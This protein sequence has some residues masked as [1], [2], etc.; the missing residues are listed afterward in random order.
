M[1]KILVNYIYNKNK[2]EYK[3]MD[4]SMVFAEMPLAVMDTDEVINEPLVVL[5]DGVMTV[6]DRKIYEIDHKKFKLTANEFGKVVEDPNG[7]LEAWLPKDTDV[8]KLRLIN[9]TLVLVENEETNEPEESKKV[10]VKKVTNKP[11]E[12]TFEKEN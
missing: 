12:E 6:T 3:L 1:A 7:V 2:D 9:N 4:E 11:A 8:S 5:K 10:K